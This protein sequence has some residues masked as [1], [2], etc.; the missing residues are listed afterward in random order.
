M[1]QAKPRFTSIEEYAALDPSDLPEGPYELV[2]GVIVEMG[3]ENFINLEIQNFLLHILSQY[4]PFYLFFRG[5][6]IEIKSRDVTSR[7]PDL[8][9]LTDEGRAMMPRDKRSLI[10]LDMPVPALV[11]EVVSPGDPGTRN[12]QRDYLEK[13]VE[14]ADRGIPEYWRIDPSRAVVTVLWLVE[15]Q[16]QENSFRDRDL[17]LSPT[18]PALQLT[19][20]QILT[21]GQ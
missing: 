21:A 16:Y 1:V 6:E 9:M 13:P 11:V 2:D 20:E 14:Y 8:L 18:F 5:V 19:A 17:V 4:M 7:V 3:A 12:Y 15:G 10:T